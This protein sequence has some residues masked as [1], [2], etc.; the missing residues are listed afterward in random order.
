MKYSRIIITLFATALMS[1]TMF[2]QEAT[3]RIN[4]RQ[5][6]QQKRIRQGVRSGQLTRKE[7][8]QLKVGEARIQHDKMMAKADGRVTRAERAKLTREQN[9]ESK[10]IYNKKHNHHH[11]Y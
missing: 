6:D 11:R 3:P 1:G 8:R 7:A 4:E 10:A 2:A 5:V 9:R